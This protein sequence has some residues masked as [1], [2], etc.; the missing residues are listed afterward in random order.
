MFFPWQNVNLFAIDMCTLHIMDIV[1]DINQRFGWFIAEFFGHS[2]IRSDFCRKCV[3]LLFVVRKTKVLSFFVVFVSIFVMNFDC[4]FNF[5]SAVLLLLNSNYSGIIP[6]SKRIDDIDSVSDFDVFSPF[7][8]GAFRFIR[9]Q[10]VGI[11]LDF[12]GGKFIVQIIRY[13]YM[14]FVDFQNSSVGPKILFIGS[15][16]LQNVDFAAFLKKHFK[17]V[18]VFRKIQ[19]RLR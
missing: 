6:A 3:K 5:S 9:S 14:A 8:C 2:T 7:K 16:K 11:A 13:K 1:D 15:R 4:D 18:V 12:D 19:I 10:V 17:I